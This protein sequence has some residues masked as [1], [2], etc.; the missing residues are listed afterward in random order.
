MV[1]EWIIISVP[2]FLYEMSAPKYDTA[3]K[4]S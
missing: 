1:A 4:K 2:F 3:K